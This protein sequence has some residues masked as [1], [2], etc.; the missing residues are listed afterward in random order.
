[1]Y[2][3]FPE[4]TAKYRIGVSRVLL[5]LMNSDLFDIALTLYISVAMCRIAHQVLVP[6]TRPGNWYQVDTSTSS[7]TWYQYQVTGNRYSVPLHV[8]VIVLKA[9]TL[10]IF[11]SDRLF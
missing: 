6:G 3:S 1:M 9:K 7:G 5:L 10:A 11:I 8:A 2:N 4:L